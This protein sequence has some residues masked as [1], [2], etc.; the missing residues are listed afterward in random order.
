M[1]C[2]LTIHA[3]TSN[4]ELNGQEPDGGVTM[5]FWGIVLIAIGIGSLF[6][7]SVW[8]IILI[9]IGA[10][11]ISRVLFGS[12]S[13]GGWSNWSCWC[14]PSFRGRGKDDSRRQASD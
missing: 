12:K 7:L 6:D 5:L 2:R 11:M 14:G 3:I 10:S 9:A 13:K 1:A 4:Q 8:P